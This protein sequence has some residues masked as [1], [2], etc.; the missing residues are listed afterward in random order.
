MFKL[1]TVTV[2][3][4]NDIFNISVLMIDNITSN[5]IMTHK[6]KGNGQFLN[7]LLKSS[8]SKGILC[9]YEDFPL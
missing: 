2:R 5:I 7:A 8:K 4:I 1:T 3:V 6:G 9:N